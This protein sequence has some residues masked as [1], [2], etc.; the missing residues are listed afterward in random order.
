[1][2]VFML[3]LLVA[4]VMC[5]QDLAFALV[6]VSNFTIKLLFPSKSSKDPQFCS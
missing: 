5:V 3:L 6:T 1:M 4:A 2:P